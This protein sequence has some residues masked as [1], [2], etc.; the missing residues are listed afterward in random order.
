[1]NRMSY[2]AEEILTMAETI[3]HNA[4]QYYHQAALF[5]QDQHA[6]NTFNYLSEMEHNHARIFESMHKELSPQEKGVQ[7]YDPGNEMLYYLEGMAGLHAWEG[8]AGP[9]TKL[10]GK[11]PL[12]HVYH[13]AINAERDTVSFYTFIKDFVPA[14]KGKEK[15]DTI[16]REEMSHI[17]ILNKEL[18]KVE[19]L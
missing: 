8:K 1:M 15:V 19:S 2:S 4:S 17:A 7:P 9:S 18:A 6:Q 16:I 13:I 5:A 14:H 12:K 10:T 11:E 3:E